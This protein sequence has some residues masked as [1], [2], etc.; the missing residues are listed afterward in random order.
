MGKT[1][2]K[3]TR[4]EVTTKKLLGKGTHRQ[5]E[6]KKHRGRKRQ[7][8]SGHTS[9]SIAYDELKGKQVGDRGVIGHDTLGTKNAE[10]WIQGVRLNDNVG[11]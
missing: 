4:F 7:P 1:E 11:A 10:V 5:L 3:K 8:N 9:E 2:G 6:K